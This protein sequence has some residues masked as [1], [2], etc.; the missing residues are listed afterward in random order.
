MEPFS[1]RPFLPGDAEAVQTMILEKQAEPV[2][3]YDYAMPTEEHQLRAL[4]AYFASEPSYL[5]I[6]VGD[7]PVGYAVLHVQSDRGSLGY[8]LRPA[9]RG[10]G[11]VNQ[12]C[13]ALLARAFAGGMAAA[14]AGAALANA[15]SVAVLTRLGFR[16][17]RRERVSFHQ[18]DQG[19]PLEFEAGV[20]ELTRARWEALHPCA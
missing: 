10:R 6:C 9:W 8:F 14:E 12:A 13:A 2:A 7:M 17:V 18:D 5:A 4:A 16:Q 20:Y 15:P 1:L 11:W 3:V 19:R